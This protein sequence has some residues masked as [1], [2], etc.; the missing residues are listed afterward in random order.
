MTVVGALPGRL[1]ITARIGSPIDILVPVLQDDG[2]AADLTGWTAKAQV[3]ESNAAGAALLHEFSV[4]IGTGTVTLTAT[5]AQTAA[6]SW[7]R[8]P[9]DLILLDASSV[10]APVVAGW[11]TAYPRITR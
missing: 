10:P 6:W 4:A 9:W 3:R 5:G 8:A 11:I 1:D 7:F 2:T